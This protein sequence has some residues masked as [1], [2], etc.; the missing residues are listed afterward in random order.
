MFA[1]AAAICAAIV[2]GTAAIGA[3][4]QAP[5]STTGPALTA[6]SAPTEGLARAFLGI[7]EVKCAQCH[8]PQVAKPPNGFGYVTDLRKL[9]EA[10]QVVPGKPDDSPLYKIVHSGMMPKTGAKNGGLTND[11]IELIRSW[12]A[13]G[14]PPAVGLAA[15]GATTAPVGPGPAPGATAYERFAWKVGRYHL[16]I[17]HFPIA[18]LLAGVLA[19]LLNRYR[20]APERRWCA[21]FCLWLGAIGAVAAATTGWLLDSSKTWTDQQEELIDTH[22]WLG[23]SSAALAVVMV[24]L[25][26]VLLRKPGK[27]AAWIYLA[28]V[29]G[30]GVLVSLAGHWGGM[31]AWGQDFFSW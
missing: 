18:L 12:I 30:A 17:V 8:G 31:V 6:G 10:G 3:Q 26:W 13:A 28:G 11:Q 9:V 23:T 25:G 15:A 2:L 16:Q 7:V 20:P 4:G 22:G 19:E 14:A 1:R 21:R 24:I 5:T 27:A 29:V